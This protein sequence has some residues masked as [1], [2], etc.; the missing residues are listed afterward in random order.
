MQAYR[1]KPRNSPHEQQGLLSSSRLPDT[2]S[3]PKSTGWAILVHMWWLFT[4]THMVIIAA[5]AVR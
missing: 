2:G 5:A 3:C 1:H 4:T